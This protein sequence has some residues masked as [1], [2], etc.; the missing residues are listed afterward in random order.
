MQVNEHR[1]ENDS[2]A[3][4]IA[5]LG[6]RWTFLILRES[7]FGVRRYG[8]L[9]RTLGLSRN[10][11]SDRLKRLTA[12]GILERRR[13]RQDPD[14]YE[15]ALTQCGKDLYPAIVALLRWGDEYLAGPEG[16]PLV[17][18]HTTC[19]HDAAPVLVCGHCTQPIRATDIQPQPG[20]GAHAER[21][22]RQEAL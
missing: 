12:H 5:I 7:F 18:H 13:Y 14:R 6:D 17:L 22:L 19:G 2:I 20:P 4:A 21:P 1:F 3:R 15:Y 16:P 9:A 8:K 10:I 11:L